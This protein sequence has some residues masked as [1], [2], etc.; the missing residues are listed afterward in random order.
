MLLF[1]QGIGVQ[2][3]LV[4]LLIGSPPN[5][6][7]VAAV[8]SGGKKSLGDVAVGILKL[9]V[10][11]RSMKL[12]NLSQGLDLGQ[13]NSETEVRPVHACRPPTVSLL[14]LTL[15][16]VFKVLVDKIPD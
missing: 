16:R 6:R 5:V 8:E 11:T 9:K 3:G 10:S 4:M 14:S 2:L 15:C 13:P 1:V 12:S 7:A